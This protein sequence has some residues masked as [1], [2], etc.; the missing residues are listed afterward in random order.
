MAGLS[1]RRFLVVGLGSAAILT[2][3]GWFALRPGRSVEG[4]RALDEDGVQFIA[5]LVPAVLAGAL[6]DEPA[7][8]A[9]AVRET[10]A[11]FD[12]AVSGLTPAVQ[13]E[14]AQLLAL[15]ALVPSRRLLAGVSRPWAEASAEEVSAFLAG[16]RHGRLDL[17][18]AGY[19]ALTQLILAAWY[20]NPSAWAGIGY[21]GAP[22]IGEKPA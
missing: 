18:R 10:V 21:P 6:P 14:L 9:A 4:F 7:A 8:R 20:G 17:M 1:R 12:R 19:Q 13:A 3:A 16:W 22:A 5:A 11:A 15:V 2:A